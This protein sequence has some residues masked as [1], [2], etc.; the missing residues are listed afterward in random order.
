MSER[1]DSIDRGTELAER[2]RAEA[3]IAVRWEGAR[4][5]EVT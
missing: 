4:A 2:T 5:E 1:G 3:E